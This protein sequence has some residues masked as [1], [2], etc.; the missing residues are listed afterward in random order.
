MMLKRSEFD[1]YS[2][3]H[4]AQTVKVSQSSA[5]QWSRSGKLKC[6]RASDGSRLLDD[7]GLAQLRALAKRSR[8]KFVA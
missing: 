7:K 4:A 6:L 3:G 8:R 5:Y 2:L 1:F